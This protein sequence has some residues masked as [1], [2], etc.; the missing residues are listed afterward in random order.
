MRW[1]TDIQFGRAQC[2]GMVEY[3]TDV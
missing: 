2:E 3:S 1:M